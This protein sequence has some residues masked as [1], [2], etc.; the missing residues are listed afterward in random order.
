[1]FIFTVFVKFLNER[2][3]DTREEKARNSQLRRR[4]RN[5]RTSANFRTGAKFS[6]S[7]AAPFCFYHNFFIRTPFWVILILLESLESV[8]SKYSHK[9]HF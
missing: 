5:F 4:L 1:M 7:T 3:Q 9:E 8:K 2:I 6:H